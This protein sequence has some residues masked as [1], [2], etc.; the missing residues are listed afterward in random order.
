MEK[1]HA[2]T[3]TPAQRKKL[4][5]FHLNVPVKA[6][7][8]KGTRYWQRSRCGAWARR[9]NRPCQAKALLPSGRCKHH[10]GLSTGPKSPEGRARARA[11][12]R[13]YPAKHCDAT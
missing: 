3:L 2:K 11:N 7:G 12:L 9:L 6:M 1:Q 4:R 13:Q 8:W 5:K 10:G